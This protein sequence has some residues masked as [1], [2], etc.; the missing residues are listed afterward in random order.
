MVTPQENRTE[1]SLPSVPSEFRTLPVRRT[2]C[3]GLDAHLFFPVG[4]K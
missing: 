1:M 4:A 3:G 2:F